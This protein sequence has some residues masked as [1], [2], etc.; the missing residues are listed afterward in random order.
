[1]SVIERGLI[2]FVLVVSIAAFTA[3]SIRPK[4]SG[5]DEE[6]KR[7]KRVI[8]DS[9]TVVIIGGGVAGL[10]A[11]NRLRTNGVKN[12]IIIEAMNRLGGR[13]DTITYR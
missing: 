1:M 10:S 7:V 6:I 11:A 2:F 5:H 12:V 4:E 3:L 9:Q 13:I 8:T